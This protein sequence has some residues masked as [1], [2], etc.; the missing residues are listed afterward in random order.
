MI[1]LSPQN[2]FDSARFSFFT[3]LTQ[4]SEH[5]YPDIS[6]TKNFVE[7]PLAKMNRASTHNI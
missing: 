4:L 1:S 2:L 3:P 6:E 5:S 7:E